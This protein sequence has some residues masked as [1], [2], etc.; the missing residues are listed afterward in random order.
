MTDQMIAPIE[1]IIADVAILRQVTWQ[2]A[3]EETDRLVS[4]LILEGQAITSLLNDLIALSEK[5]SE[6]KQQ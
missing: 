6:N 3:P 5:D 2:M 4:E 1:T